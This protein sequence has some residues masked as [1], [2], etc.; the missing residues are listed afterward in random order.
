MTLL[1]FISEK[2][3]IITTGMF[4]LSPLFFLRPICI[5]YG[6]LILIKN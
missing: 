2:E 1:Y 3:H 6:T 4:R 5:T